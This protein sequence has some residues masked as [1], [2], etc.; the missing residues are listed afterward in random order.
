LNLVVQVYK[1]TKY[2]NE[3]AEFNKK[4]KVDKDFGE[5][6]V[7]NEVESDEGIKQDLQV[8]KEKINK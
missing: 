1:S 2:R 8:V 4:L 7:A 6:D 5:E 3:L